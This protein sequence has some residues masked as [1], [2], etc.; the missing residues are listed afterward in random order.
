MG[1]FI[2]LLAIP[3]ARDGRRDLFVV[4]NVGQGSW[5]TVIIGEKCQ[6][7]DSGG[8]RFP[9]KLLSNR[10]SRRQ[11]EFYYS[12]WDLDHVGGLRPAR[13]LFA[14]ICIG[15]KPAGETKSVR[16]LALFKDLPDCAKSS[17]RPQE[18]S[19][20][21]K[22]RDS[23]SE[24]R[25]FISRERI[26]FPGDSP[27]GE[28]KIWSQMLPSRIRWLVAGHHGSRTSTSAALLAR[29][30]HLHEVLVSARKAKYGHPHRE[31]VERLRAGRRPL[32]RTEE[33]GN[34]LFEL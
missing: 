29:L 12:H 31:V 13:K 34:L 7:F 27:I 23:N 14:A 30:P 25:I 18:I 28:E 32:L 9:E 21:H 1:L 15:A 16:K 20:I 6:H 22:G 11:N 3:I 17:D 26:L 10:C 19:W 4:W 24:S 5:S 8:E 2:F 33:W